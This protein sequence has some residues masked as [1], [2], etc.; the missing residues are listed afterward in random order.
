MLKRHIEELRHRRAEDA[1]ANKLVGMFAS[2]EQRLL[3]VVAA[4]RAQGGGRIALVTSRGA[5]GRGIAQG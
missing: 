2:Y 3:A 5:A 1:K 4:T